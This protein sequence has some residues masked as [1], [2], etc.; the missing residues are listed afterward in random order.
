[1]EPT[2]T[3]DNHYLPENEYVDIKRYI[4]LFI[5]NWYWFALALFI[6]ATLAYGLNRYS[7]KIYTVSSSLL[8]KDEK[9]GGGFQV[10][11]T[12]MPGSGIYNNQQNL[13]NEI[14]ILKSFSL[15]YRVLES[16]PDFHIIYGGLGRRNIVESKLYKTSCPFEVQSDS[17]EYQPI[18]VKIFITFIS[19]KLYS[20]RINGD[21]K[22][23]TQLEFGQ[24]FTSKGFSFILKLRYP[25]QFKFDDKTSNKYYFYFERPENL[26]NN[27]SRR[28]KIE[29]INIDASL[30][31]LSVSGSVRDKECDYLNRLMDY[32]IIQGI[33][34][35]NRIADSTITFIDKQLKEISASLIMAENK[36]KDFKNE[37]K[38]IDVS[39]EGS[40]IQDQLIRFG[41]DKI[42]LE[43]K[44]KYYEY[45]VN[46]L[47]SKNE[48]GDIISPSTMGITDQQL[49]GLVLELASLQ[50]QKK[51]LT[52]NLS[53]DQAPIILV[54]EGINNARSALMENVK[55]N[56]DFVKNSISDVNKKISEVEQEIGKLP[57][58]EIEMINIQRTFDL[59]STIYNF[60]LEKKAEAGITRASNVSD[61]RII[62]RAESFNSIL[63]RPKTKQNILFALILGLFIP[64]FFISLVYNLNNKIID[65]DDIVN[66]TKTPI[67]GYISHNNSNNEIPVNDKPGSVLSESFRSVRTSL[68]YFIKE[69]E[70]PVIT[71]TST[72]TSEGK[73]F[74]SVNLAAVYAMLGKKILLIGLDLRKP[75]IHKIL[76]VSNSEGM[77]EYL[78][79]NCDYSKVIQKTPINNL[80]YAASGPVP[81]NPAELIEGSRMKS[82]IEKA[83]KEFDLIIIDTPPVAI[84]S[85]VLLLSGYVD[86]NI[87]VVRQRY[88]SKNTLDLIQEYYQTGKFKNIG[89]VINDI[90]LSGYYGY[91]LRYGYSLGYG[92]SYGSN[93]YGEY[94]NLKYG[95]SD[96]EHGY[97]NE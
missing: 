75:R 37:K 30:V 69:A 86:V 53:R 62:D 31:Q 38:L 39:K 45:L 27:Y 88:S 60:L 41:N 19:N 22:I 24:R 76:D 15:N 56:V 17:L 91:G 44:Q 34:V 13:Q 63:I 89:I 94:A 51:Q 46:Y 43:L 92:Y 8:I 67:I 36:L 73:T 50:R 10:A 83:K 25:E 52:M 3:P 21:Y 54:E 61:N 7:E 64:A 55:N 57:G 65:K 18:K 47:N 9:I 78:S 82:F 97:Y 20:L 11:E 29:P 4:S 79:G 26:A 2:S 90:N 81:P 68:R 5:S 84:V 85:D 72:I 23:D 87:F 95:Y 93:Y 71:V 59:N 28:L 32:Y 80:F 77:S 35:K 40:L 16:L 6:S 96:K 74:I 12:F 42:N 48:S 70:H 58:T 1:M 66:R 14:G 33:E 49:G